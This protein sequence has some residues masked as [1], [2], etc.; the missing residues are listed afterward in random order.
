MI[1]VDGCKSDKEISSF[2]NLEEILATV[3]QDEKMDD[4]V[5]TDVFVNNE[6]FSE[7]YPHQAEDMSCDAISSVEVRS[8][9]AAELAVDMSAEMGKVA[10]MMGSGARNVA[11]LFRDA[12]DADALELLQDL[13]DV[14]RDFMGML[15]ALRERY[16]GGADEEFTLK[17][18]KLADL[19]S[20]MSDVLENED[21]ILLA[22]LLEYEFLPLCDEWLVVSEH[23]HEQMTKRIAQ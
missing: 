13:L 14:T 8:V 1:I 4:R 22:D 15:S 20:E 23:L 10:R 17:A 21:W 6:I 19:L 5:V 12:S 18:E 3:M 9:P 11:R 7:I 16:L 2:A